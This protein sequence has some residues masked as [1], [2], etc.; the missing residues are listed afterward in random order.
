MDQKAN[1][2]ADLSAVLSRQETLANQHQEEAREEQKEV[3]KAT[4]KMDT[5]LE[6]IKLEMSE[7]RPAAI[8]G[9]EQTSAQY[10][11]LR[12]EKL[13]I[14]RALQK[15]MPHFALEGRYHPKNDTTPVYERG[16]SKTR[17]RGLL[18]RMSMESVRIQWAN[19][20]DAEF[21]NKWP[22]TVEHDSLQAA[23][24]RTRNVHPLP[25][26]PEDNFPSDLDNV[27]EE[28]RGDNA[29]TQQPREVRKDPPTSQ[30]DSRLD[31]SEEPSRDWITRLLNRL[32][33]GSA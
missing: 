1:T 28:S 2:V 21:A 32:K 3:R 14:R 27:S 8:A 17:R 7:K 33:Y 9:D 25:E 19:Q 30:I 22:K 26:L 15:P 23:D 18:P 16:P 24:S 11:A 4:D 5:R 12:G 29:S 20:D 31:P 10:K 13:R 6:R